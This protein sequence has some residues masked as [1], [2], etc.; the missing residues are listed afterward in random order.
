MMPWFLWNGEDSRTKG[1]YI[2][3]L[4]PLT[5]AQERTE[6]IQIPGRAG[7]LTLLEGPDVFA[8]VT[9]QCSI[10][11]RE[12]DRAGLKSWLRG[13]GTVVFS[14]ETDRRHTAR[15]T[16][17]VAFTKPFNGIVQAVIPFL[18]DPLAE[19]YPPE[20]A[21]AWD[22]DTTYLGVKEIFN[23]GD[24]AAKP[25]I[26]GR[27]SGAGQSLSFA[28]DGVEDVIIAFERTSDTDFSFCF[29]TEAMIIYNTSTGTDY[30]NLLYSGDPRKLW[31]PTGGGHHVKWSPDVLA[32]MSVM[33]RWRWL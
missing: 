31:I 3:Q 28:T 7:E 10:W 15:I 21:I 6:Q 29:D 32:A 30:T 4:P 18:C 22:G 33:P 14:N 27:F 1:V 19:Q 9:L 16:G 25:L 20:T 12:E 24:V 13:R 26:Y 17:E 8:Q 5:K 11:A 23:P 2:S